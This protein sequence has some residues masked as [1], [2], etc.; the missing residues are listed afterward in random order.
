MALIENEQLTPDGSKTTFELA[1]TYKEGTVMVLVDGKLTYEFYEVYNAGDAPQEIEFDRA[2]ASTREIYVSYYQADEPN[3]LNQI[4]YITPA[5][6]KLMTRVSSVTSTDDDDLE[7]IIREAEE[8]VDRFVA[9]PYKGYHG[10]VGQQRLFPRQ[11]DE[12]FQ[13]D[14]DVYP[15]DYVGI[16]S[17]LTKAALYAVEN[18]V[19]TGNV[20]ADA[21][22]GGIISE[23]LGDYSYTRA[24]A[25][26]S[27]SLDAGVLIGKRARS[28]LSKYRK[29]YR[30]MKIGQTFENND[31]LNSR[32]RFSRDNY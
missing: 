21:E 6:A 8:L 20:T 4:R 11:I 22:A 24:E 5:Q 31:L 18:L 16:P 27:S 9:Y 15:V 28:L 17:D 1:Q 23:R 29:A 19:L 3:T 32:Q 26:G 14:T 25:K 2:P 12:A 10:Q 13:T 30:G 7:K